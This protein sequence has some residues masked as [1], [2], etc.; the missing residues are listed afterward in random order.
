MAHG[1]PSEH[2]ARVGGRGEGEG[3][4]AEDPGAEEAAGRGAGEG[5]LPQA[6][7]GR[8]PQAVSIFVCCFD[9]DFLFPP[10]AP[11]AFGGRRLGFQEKLTLAGAQG[12]GG[13]SSGEI[14]VGGGRIGGLLG[15]VLG[16]RSCSL[17]GRLCFV[18]G[19]RYPRF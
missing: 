17:L 5:R 6:P 3:G 13:G 1:E 7:G 15:G 2:R 11:I 14:G 8:R 12:G 19:R 16:F 10:F 18:L 9:F 4:A